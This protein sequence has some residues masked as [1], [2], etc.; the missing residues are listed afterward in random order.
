MKKDRKMKRLK[1]K[2]KSKEVVQIYPMLPTKFSYIE[3]EKLRE[4]EKE[5]LKDKT[6]SLKI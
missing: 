1:R 2:M 6:L 5:L 3:R 4:F